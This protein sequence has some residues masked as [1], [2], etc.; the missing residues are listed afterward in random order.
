VRVAI[1]L[2]KVRDRYEALGRMTWPEVVVLID[3][4]LLVVLW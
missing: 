2:D 3:F 1:N 4:A